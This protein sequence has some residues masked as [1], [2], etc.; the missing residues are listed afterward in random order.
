MGYLIGAIAAFALGIYIG[1]GFPGLPGR[2]DRVLPKG[3]TR[4]KKKYFTPLDLL[5]REE[6]SSDR[7]RRTGK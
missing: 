1:L 7:R 2:E 6:R 5:R 3:K 4:R